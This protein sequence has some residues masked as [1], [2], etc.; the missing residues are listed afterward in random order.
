M[1]LQPWTPAIAVHAMVA[2]AA[3]VPGAFNV[4][5]G[6][7]GDRL[8]RAVGRTW[9]I[10]MLFVSTGS[11][12]IGG[13]HSYQEPLGIFLHALAAWTIISLCLGV[14]FARRHKVGLH[15]GLM[16]GT[17]LG[18]VGATI[19]VGAVPGG[20]V[21]TYFQSYPALFTAIT[22]GLVALSILLIQFLAVVLARRRPRPAAVRATVPGYTGEGSPHD[23]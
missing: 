17:Y 3:V 7:K 11:F 10:F 18:F 5:R 13:L 2:T 21:P 16:V 14:F 12:F 22:L 20:R 8:H 1:V 6:K 4:L 23:P 9:V 19:V 15:R